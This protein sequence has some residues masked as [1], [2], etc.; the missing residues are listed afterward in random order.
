MAV[1]VSVV[2]FWSYL[3]LLGRIG[4]DR[5][6]YATVLFPVVALGISTVYEGY[7]WTAEAALGVGLV[8]LG[9]AVV[10]TRFSTLKSGGKS[11]GAPGA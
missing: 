6:G 7:L 1:A 9:N 5:A 2:A 4:A 10:L 8:L 11:T 3:T